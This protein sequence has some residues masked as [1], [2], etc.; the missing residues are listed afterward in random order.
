[1][2]NLAHTIF[3][4][5]WN[6]IVIYLKEQRSPFILYTYESIVGSFQMAVDIY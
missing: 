6:D 3:C 5:L 2:S 4:H 1:M